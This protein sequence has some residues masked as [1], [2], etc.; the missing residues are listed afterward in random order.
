MTQSLQRD[1]NDPLVRPYLNDRCVG[2][3]QQMNVVLNGRSCSAQ[4]PT[5]AAAPH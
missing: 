3:T 1:A 5:N 2:L 4:T